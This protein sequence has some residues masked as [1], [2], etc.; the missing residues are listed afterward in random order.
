[1][2]VV[3]S[4]RVHV[5]KLCSILLSNPSIGP[6]VRTLALEYWDWHGK[7]ELSVDERADA[8]L[9]ILSQT[10]GALR[11]IG[12][13][14]NGIPMSF[15]MAASI[16]WDGFTAMARC[17]GHTLREFSVKIDSTAHLSP[18]VFTDLVALRILEWKCGATFLLTDIPRDGFPNLEDLWI[19]SADESFLTALSLMEYA[20][21]TPLLLHPLT[22]HR[23]DSLRRVTLSDDRVNPDAFFDAHGPKLSEISLLY[24]N[25]ATSKDKIIEVCSNLRSITIKSLPYNHVGA[26]ILSV[27]SFSPSLG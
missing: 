27:S 19:F 12:E 9:T 7:D 23:L 21:V 26:N 4:E 20:L 18:T 13:A 24:S 11:I 15:H 6:H 16:S 8:M 14:F 1:V 3:L 10:T 5:S 25:L 22:S 2:D 17:S